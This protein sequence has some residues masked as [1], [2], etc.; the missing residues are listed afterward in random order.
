MVRRHQVDLEAGDASI[1][2]ELC[3]SILVVGQIG[4]RLLVGGVHLGQEGGRLNGLAL[5]RGVDQLL[6]VDGLED[7]AANLRLVEGGLLRVEHQEGVAVAGLGLDVPADAL[8]LVLC[9][10]GNGFHDVD[11]A[12]DGGG[13]TGGVILEG[14]PLEGGDLRGLV[15]GVVLVGNSGDLSRRDVLVLVGAGADRLGL[16]RV[17][18]HRRGDNAD[19][20]ETLLQ[21]GEGVLEL[22]RDGVVVLGFDTV[23]EG[24]ELTVD[25]LLGGRTLVGSDEVCGG[26]G[27]AVGELRAVAQLHLVLGVGDLLRVTGGQRR[28]DGVVGH[29]ETVQALEDLPVRTDAES[30]GGDRAV[31]GGLVGDTGGDHTLRSVGGLRAAVGRR[32]AGRSAAARGQDHG[33]SCGQCSAGC[34]VFAHSH[35]LAPHLR[36]LGRA[37]LLFRSLYL[38]YVV[39][40]INASDI[41]PIALRNQSEPISTDTD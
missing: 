33:G 15:A 26:H 40:Q 14:L 34:E 9:G 11:S 31:I 16:E 18:V 19:V 32:G 28:A 4:R 3:G 22:D 39:R 23:D 6:L 8:E 17:F 1:A 20:N 38:S 35:V 12:A 10:G 27:G 25:R 30:R 5:E 37:V 21:V 7:R 41:T 36:E 2:Q 24:E 29:V 13:E